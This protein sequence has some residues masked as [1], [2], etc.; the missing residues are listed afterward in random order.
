EAL[1]VSVLRRRDEIDV[2]DFGA[3]DDLDH[4]RDI[5]ERNTGRPGVVRLYALL[6]AEGLAEDHPAHAYFTE[7]FADLRGRITA[8]LRTTYGDRLPSGATP[9]QAAAL[10]IAAMDGLQ[11]QWSYDPEAV[12]MPDL[13]ALLTDVLRG[14][15][16]RPGAD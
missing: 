12:A 3:L 8:V 11:L 13:M 16:T 2:A 15:G 7:R 5:V 6:S 4:L 9:E 14:G 10:L 1:L